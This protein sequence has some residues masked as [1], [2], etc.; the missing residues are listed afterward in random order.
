MKLDEKTWKTFQQHLGYNDEEMKRFRKN[1][2]SEDVQMI[3]HLTAVDDHSRYR[4][5]KCVS[6]CPHM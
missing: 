5:I 6:V 3:N 2:R 1:P 4:C